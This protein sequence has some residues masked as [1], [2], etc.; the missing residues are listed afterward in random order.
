MKKKLVPLPELRLPSW[1]LDMLKIIHKEIAVTFICKFRN[2]KLNENL[3]YDLYKSSEMFKVMA[4][5]MGKD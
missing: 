3:I 4:E 1:K 2:V 5:K